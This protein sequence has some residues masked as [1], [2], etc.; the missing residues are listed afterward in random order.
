MDKE[1]IILDFLAQLTKT[2]SHLTCALFWG[3]KMNLTNVDYRLKSAG[4]HNLSH[5]FPKDNVYNLQREGGKVRDY[6]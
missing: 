5:S 2:L 4:Q 3:K 1:R 6:Q